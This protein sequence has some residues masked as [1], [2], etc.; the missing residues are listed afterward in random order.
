MIVQVSVILER[1]TV[2][3]SC[4]H[5]RNF[6]TTRSSAWTKLAS[7]AMS[8]INYQCFVYSWSFGILLWETFT[9]GGNPY[10]GLPTE[11]LLDY[12]SEGKR[13][14]MPAKCPLEVYTI[15][16]DCWNHDADDRPHFTTLVEQLA[17]ILEKNSTTVLT[18]WLIVF[19]MTD[20]LLMFLRKLRM[21]KMF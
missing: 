13:M 12:L 4:W 10:P 5:W 2:S 17:K 21:Y 19:F 1:T 16:R 7:R 9:L 8:I 6:S 20:A 11:Q 15:M 14:D 18:D 3:S